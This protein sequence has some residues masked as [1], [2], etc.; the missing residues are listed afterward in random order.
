M[1]DFVE[2]VF[3]PAEA[4]G[5]FDGP[6]LFELPHLS[7]AEQQYWFGRWKWRVAR[8]YTILNKQGKVIPFRPN[9]AQREF[10]ENIHGTDIIL[11]AR[12]LGFSTLIE[13]IILDSSMWNENIAS[14]IITITLDDGVKLLK[15]KILA[16][17]KR[18]PPELHDRFPL[19]TVS[20]ELLEFK[21]GSTITVGISLR[22]GTYQILHI[23]ELGKIAARFPMRAQEIKTG[24]F[25][26]VPVGM[27]IFV[28]S[29]AEGQEGLFYDIC[30]EAL[31]RDYRHQKPEQGE[32]KMH[33]F[34]WYEE[35]TY[36]IETNRPL[37]RKWKI[38]FKALQKA[39]GRIFTMGQM[40]WYARKAAQQKGDMKREFPST[41]EEAFEASVE[42]AIFREEI[43]R[44]YD[45]SRYGSFPYDP[46]LGAVY[47]FWDIGRNDFNVILLGQRFSP[48]EW[49][50]FECVYGQ[51]KSLPYYVDELTRLKIRHRINWGMHVL[52][53]DGNNHEFLSVTSRKTAIENALMSEAI[54]V[55]RAKNLYSDIEQVRSFWESSTF[56]AGSNI[57]TFMKMA[58]N[59]KW[60]R[61]E[62][63][64][65][66]L[67]E[68]EHNDPSHFM[69]AYRTA[70]AA[71]RLNLLDQGEFGRTYEPEE[72]YTPQSNAGY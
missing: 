55:D 64:G 46:A 69:D 52:P 9:A 58:Q 19:K 68:P 36:T 44:V 66:W 65:T 29:T 54:V 59:Y 49:N 48:G 53:H 67:K 15:E 27:H 57:S 47:T 51:G 72:S 32:F 10:M 40:Q 22:G 12:Q 25:N 17:Y 5:D 13:I 63:L 56:N 21:N 71:H 70:A 1:P 38:Y 28:E 23:S 26:T 34:P 7:E 31:D 3:N 35:P 18:L 42:G 62:R 11:K 8:L 37:D 43:A 41:P 14:G 50:F 60:R 45:Q 61:D 20:S 33:F 4:P 2:P 6:E 16:V 24:A 30:T 39:T